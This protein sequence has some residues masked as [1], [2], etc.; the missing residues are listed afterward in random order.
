[1]PAVT[2]LASIF[3]NVPPGAWAAISSDEKRVLSYDADFG[4]AMRKAKEMGEEEPIMMRVP[5]K[6]A[7]LIL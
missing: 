1:V 4:E 2:D 3:A 5:E 7:A 6:D